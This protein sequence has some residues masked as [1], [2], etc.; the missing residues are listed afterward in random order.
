MDAID[1]FLKVA[2]HFQLGHLDTEA[3]HPDTVGLSEWAQHDLPQGIAKLRDV[4][5]HMLSTLEDRLTALTPLT[6]AIRETLE[7]GHRLFL[8][9]CGATGRLSLSIEVFCRADGLI[10]SEYREQVI[11]FMAGG[12]AALIRSIERFEDHPEYGER[13]LIELGFT[14]GD[15]LIASTEGG[16]TPFVIGATEAASKRSRRS[17]FFLYCNPDAEL[18]A[19]SVDRSRRV[20][21]NPDIHKI[22][23][24]TGPMALSGSTRMQAST[25][26]M[27]AIGYACQAWGDPKHL[28][29]LLAPL[30][31]W[32]HEQDMAFLSGF[33]ECEAS[34]YQNGEF[35]LYEPGPFGITVM[36]DTTER[37]PT[38]TLVPFE[39][40]RQPD[41]P[42]S[43]CYLHVP[44]TSSPAEAWQAVLHRSPRTVGWGD[45]KHLTSQD[46][47]HGF[48]FSDR[49]QTH[50]D[51]RCGQAQQHR[52]CICRSQDKDE[53]IWELAEQNATISIT[54]LTP[55]GQHL[56]LKM[57]LNMHSTL[58]M[59]RLHR[60][61]SNL[62]TYVS[63]TNNKLIDRSI[64]YAQL[65]LKRRHQLEPSYEALARCL[66]EQRAQLQPN[67]SIVLKIVAAFASQA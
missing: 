61:E 25:I 3:S 58:V 55:L 32:H 30:Q 6:I 12:D 24:A 8:C 40:T 57:L 63:S 47:I 45:L 49:V 2:K 60:Y 9:G 28:P 20:L 67:E 59:G 41:D 37:S 54:D 43:W 33:I 46:A 27:A 36:T 14:E 31:Q 50:R 19:G 4:D 22:N 29:S 44:G 23:L 51:V 64:R 35:I 16:E 39:T 13:Q 66:F 10:P 34:I 5:A 15:L 52:F 53:L 42:P 11:A 26:L 38:F 17:P 62:M 65:L 21:N 7:S 18:M 48:D 1:D 56:A